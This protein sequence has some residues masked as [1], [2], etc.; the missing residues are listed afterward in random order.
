[1]LII[2]LH[3][4]IYPGLYASEKAE[5][6]MDHFTSESGQITDPHYDLFIAGREYKFEQV[7]D[8][9]LYYCEELDFMLADEGEYLTV[10]IPEE[11]YRS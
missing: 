11:I 7:D 3:V 6:I 10:D 9:R 1:M 8:S 5:A 4:T 2:T